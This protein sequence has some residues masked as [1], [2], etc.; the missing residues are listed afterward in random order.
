[1]IEIYMFVNPLNEHCLDSEKRFLKIIRNEDQKI[2]L[3]LIPVLSPRIIQNYLTENDLPKD[4]TYRNDLIDTLYSACL[5]VKAAQLQGNQ[6]G[7]EFLFHL[8]DLVGKQKIKYSKELVIQVLKSISA[9]IK[10]FESDRQSHLVTNFFKSDQQIANEMG[11]ESFS[12]AAILNYD[13]SNDFGVLIDSWTPDNVIKNLLSSR[14]ELVKKQ[15][16]HP[17]NV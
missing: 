10:L 9:D 14:P 1:M 15:S 11:V 12:K 16:N 6:I 2:C 4:L 13:S 3:R 8:Q 7:R 5:D 17:L